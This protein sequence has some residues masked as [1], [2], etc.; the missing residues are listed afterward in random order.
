MCFLW[1]RCPEQ[2]P[3]PKPCGTSGPVEGA[4]SLNS[5]LFE[6]VRNQNAPLNNKGAFRFRARNKQKPTFTHECRVFEI[7]I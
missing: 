7:G 4:L 3:A 6:R 5:S 2:D 1:N